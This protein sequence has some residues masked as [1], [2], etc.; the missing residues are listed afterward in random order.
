VNLFN[1]TEVE[2]LAVGICIF[3]GVSTILIC[4]I[5]RDIQDENENLKKTIN[6]IYS[7]VKDLKNKKEPQ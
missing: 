1:L 2:Q 6:S 4:K 5:L 7:L 3:L